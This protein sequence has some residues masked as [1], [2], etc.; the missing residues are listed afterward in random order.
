MLTKPHTQTTLRTSL[1]AMEGMMTDKTPTGCKEQV[2]IGLMQVGECVESD[3]INLDEDRGR[4]ENNER[5][6][7]N[8]NGGSQT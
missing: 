5:T 3:T 1:G 4:K 8:E 2:G 7:P 6:L